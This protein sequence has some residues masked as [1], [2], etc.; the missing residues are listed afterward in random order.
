VNDAGGNADD[1]VGAHLPD[2]IADSKTGFASQKN[3]DL[4]VFPVEM[5]PQS[6]AGTNER[7]G[8]AG[9][10]GVMHVRYRHQ[11]VL[12][13]WLSVPRRQCGHIMRIPQ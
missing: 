10:L 3:D 8:R 1:V 5:R 6:A 11:I 4:I 9:T 13:R 2:L 12:E 7:N